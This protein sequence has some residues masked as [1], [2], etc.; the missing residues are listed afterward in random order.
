MP[1]F[2][3]VLNPT[4][5]QI[6]DLVNNTL[7]V[8]R[9]APSRLLALWLH[10]PLLVTSPQG[11]MKIRSSLEANL[12]DCRDVTNRDA[13]SGAVSPRAHSGSWLGAIGYLVL[14]DQIGGAVNHLH[15]RRTPSGNSGVERALAYFRARPSSVS[16][17]T[18]SNRIRSRHPSSVESS[19]STP[20]AQGSA[21]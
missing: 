18:G 11:P 16:V 15:P 19:R 10:L 17:S 3:P 9:P 6:V 21:R 4:Q 7:N 2:R 20:L 5:D 1:Q 8:A 14:L 12:A 13:Q